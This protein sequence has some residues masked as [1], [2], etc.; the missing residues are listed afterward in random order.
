MKYTDAE[1][2]LM[3]S[4]PLHRSIKKNIM[5]GL[6]LCIDVHGP[7]DKQHLSS[8]TSRVYANVKSTLNQLRD[9]LEIKGE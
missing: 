6:R 5:D 3:L 2:V 9:K 4:G 1:L 8:A 7:I